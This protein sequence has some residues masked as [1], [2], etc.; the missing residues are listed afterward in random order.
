MRKGRKEREPLSEHALQYLEI[1]REVQRVMLTRL[2]HEDFRRQM[3]LPR[4]PR[5][6][7]ASMADISAEHLGNLETATTLLTD[8]MR[9]RFMELCHLSPREWARREATIVKELPILAYPRRVEL[10]EAAE[11]PASYGSGSKDEE[12]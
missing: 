11:P 8:K 2:R 12:P 3:R 9:A 1:R 4:V 7:M 5:K 6:L 10:L